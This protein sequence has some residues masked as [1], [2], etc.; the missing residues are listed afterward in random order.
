M[1]KHLKTNPAAP[2]EPQGRIAF[3]RQPL[4][5]VLIFLYFAA[6]IVIITPSVKELIDGAVSGDPEIV[7]HDYR[8]FYAAGTLTNAKKFD[9]LYDAH[10]FENTDFKYVE[11]WQHFS[12]PPTILLLFA[13]L[14]K[15]S[16][17]QAFAL[18][19]GLSA[20]ALILTTYLISKSYLVVAMV[21]ISPLFWRGVFT[22]QTGLITATLMGCGLYALWRNKPVISG[23]SFG[24]LIIKPHL[25][26]ALPLCLLI[27]RD[28]K[29][30]LS[31]IATV[32]IT[33][34]ISYL[35]FGVEAWQAFF[36]GMGGSIASEIPGEINNVISLT[37]WN[38][39]LF[40]TKSMTIAGIVAALGTI[41]ALY[42]TV[43]I[44]RN[45]TDI[46]PRAVSLIL[47]PAFASPY[48]H[49]YDA[50]P[51]L[52]VFSLMARDLLY[53]K[54][55]PYAGLMMLTI[56]VFSFAVF[57]TQLFTFYVLPFIFLIGLNLLAY[58][59]TK[60]SIKS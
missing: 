9:T 30:M 10:K 24:L 18:W 25:A 41:F 57:R 40:I 29:V 48:F 53:K 52:I 3:W 11:R 34:A 2:Q 7:G 45:T 56:W 50:V 14:S 49:L 59:Q 47:L 23:I 16:Y 6:S 55:A 31:G 42:I 36:H 43:Y 33:I 39:T 15:L 5:L 17:I 22:G 21:M 20:I 58:V 46:A 12:Y 13:P 38:I 19:A 54:T 32:A 51:L 1:N 28:W 4:G 27:T 8:V 35:A 26:L 60:E 37:F 44:W